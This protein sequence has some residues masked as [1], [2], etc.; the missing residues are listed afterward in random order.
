MMR[1]P[2]PDRGAGI[3]GPASR[4]RADGGFFAGGFP[5]AEDFGALGAFAG[6][7]GCFFLLMADFALRLAAFVL[8]RE[9]ME[10]KLVLLPLDGAE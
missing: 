5:T 4:R 1:V 3:G 2:S 8:R 7:D 6:G 9:R 10:G